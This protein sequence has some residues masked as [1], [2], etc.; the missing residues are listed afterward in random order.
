MLI[1]YNVTGDKRKELVAVMRDILQEATRYLGAPSFSFQVGAYV[2]DKNGTV[3]C[4]DDMDEAQITMLIRE[5]AHDGF[6]GERIGEPAKPIEQKAVETPKKENVTPTLDGFDR[7]SVEIPKADMT[8]TAME[9][10]RRL[11]ASKAT[12]LK[13]ALGTDTLLITEQADRIAFGWFR[14]T[15]DQTEIAAYYQLV[16]GLCELARTQKRVSATEQ[17]VDNE[18]YAFRCFLLRLGFIGPEFKDSR[19]VLLKKLSGNSAFRD[20]HETGDEA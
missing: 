16:Q 1:H 4:P 20:L 7:L 3:H 10:L 11:V 15:D 14:P 19:R 17:E 13:K 5:L 2:V 6:I 12:L 9:N 8:P 18:K